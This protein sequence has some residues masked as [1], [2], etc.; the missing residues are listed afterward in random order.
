MNTKQQISLLYSALAHRCTQGDTEVMRYLYGKICFN[1]PALIKT[2]NFL[3]LHLTPLELQDGEYSSEF[4][5]YWGLACM[6]ELSKFVEKNLETAKACFQLV[7]DDVPLARARLAFIELL[8]ST[9]PHKS[10]KNTCSIN[11]LR[12]YAA[13][14]DTFS[15]TALAR[16]I[17]EHF[18]MERLE[19]GLKKPCSSELPVRALNLL[20]YPLESGRPEA[21]AFY[22][23][24][25][26]NTDTPDIL[27]M[28]VYKP[29]I[30]IQSL[31]DYQFRMQICK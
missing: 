2:I 1:P 29:K 4:L 16:I 8:Q 18:L 7:K 31:Y 28:R 14:R 17:Y 22:N 5:Y 30:N 26:N 11:V 6:G 20:D 10:E 15:M 9:E 12:E 13:M 23:A 19:S 3:Q 25:M 24:M 27:T 21:V